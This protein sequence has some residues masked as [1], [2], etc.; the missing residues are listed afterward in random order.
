MRTHICK[1]KNICFYVIVEHLHFFLS[2]KWS[3]VSFLSQMNGVP[4]SSVT[5]GKDFGKVGSLSSAA[6]QVRLGKVRRV[7]SALLKMNRHCNYSVPILHILPHKFIH[8][9]STALF[10]WRNEECRSCQQL[11]IHERNE[12]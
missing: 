11:C 3:Q 6:V 9:S 1:I 12:H 7:K 10:V 4:C 2:F 8:P 5:M